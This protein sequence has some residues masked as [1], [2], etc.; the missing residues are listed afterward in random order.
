MK[1]TITTF[2]VLFATLCFAQTE[3]FQGSFDALVKKA[4]KENKPYIVDFSTS[5]CGYCH[6]FDREV[7]PDTNFSKLVNQQ[8][9][10]GRVDGDANRDL[11]I[12]Y[13]VRGYPTFI[14]FNEKGEIIKQFNGYLDAQSFLSSLNYLGY[15]VKKEDKKPLTGYAKQKK[16]QMALISAKTPNKLLLDKAF[17]AGK[18]NN[19]LTREDLII[20]NPTEEQHLSFYYNYGKN[21]LSIKQVESAVSNQ[22]IS[23]S[24]AHQLLIKQ[25]FMP[26]NKTTTDH[27]SLVNLLLLH[28][29]KNYYLLDTKAYIYNRLGQT[30]KG[31]SI[32]KKA[33]KTAAKQ[34]IDSSASDLL[35]LTF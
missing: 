28:D 34:G 23:V 25:L 12:K 31:K 17:L 6:K 30:K 7:M 11:V 16:K 27:L 15:K 3:V 22:I 24:E 10:F 9:L 33:I 35:L 1:N 32:I 29:T 20:D 8:F 2:F 4:K 14:I 21:G 5:W 19:T 18:E 26:K 13:K